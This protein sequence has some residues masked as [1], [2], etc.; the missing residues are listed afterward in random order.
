[1]NQAHRQP[2][3]MARPLHDTSRPDPIERW[4]ERAQIGAFV[5]GLLLILLAVVLL[6]GPAA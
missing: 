6:G 3:R 4:S 5:V 1:M 2:I